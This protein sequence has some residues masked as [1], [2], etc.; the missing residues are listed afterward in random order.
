MRNKLLQIQTELKVPKTQYNSHSSFYYRNCEDIFDAVK[1]LLIKYNC[2]LFVTDEV[3]SI[4]NNIYIKATAT[5][6]DN[7]NI[8]S[9][10][11][12][13]T[14]SAYARE[15]ATRKNFAEPQLTGSSSSYAR[16]YAL[17]GLFLIDDEKDSDNLPPKK[18]DDKKPEKPKGN[19]IKAMDAIKKSETLEALNKICSFIEQNAWTDDEAKQLDFANSDKRSLLK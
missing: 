6:S 4:G 2:C 19:F 5:I 3:V 18:E 9:A 1:P 11:N 15:E 16:K 17:N 14:V 12:H 7:E 13:V 8:D 10:T